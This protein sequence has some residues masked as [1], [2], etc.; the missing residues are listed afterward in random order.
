MW[1]ARGDCSVSA[2]RKRPGWGGGG[3]T[4]LRS[5]GMPRKGRKGMEQRCQHGGGSTGWNRGLGWRGRGTTCRIEQE[6]KTT[7]ESQNGLSWKGSRKA[8][9]YSSSPHLPSP[10]LKPFPHGPSQQR[11]KNCHP[12]SS[13]FCTGC[14]RRS[15]GR[16]PTDTVTATQVAVCLPELRGQALAPTGLPLHVA[17]EGGEKS[18]STQP[19]R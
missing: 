5:C 4:P 10:S 7:A 15:H 14:L 13:C 17:I 1:G 3:V 11:T 9:R 19:R 18:S 12:N 2:D 16:G 6:K 8:S